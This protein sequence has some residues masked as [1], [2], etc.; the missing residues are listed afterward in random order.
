MQIN[1]Y[2]WN[3]LL[4][5]RKQLRAIVDAWNAG[6]KVPLSYRAEKRYL[7][8]EWPALADLLDAIIE[9]E[10]NDE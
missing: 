7:R 1:Q 3:A 9:E 6:D 8:A 10:D 2:E 4:A 5:E